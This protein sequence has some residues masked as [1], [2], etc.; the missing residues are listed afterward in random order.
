MLETEPEFDRKLRALYADQDSG[1]AG[2]SRTAYCAVGALAPSG[3]QSP[4]RR[5]GDCHISC[6]DSALRE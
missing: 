1:S 3:A 4:R 6:G 2:K 5:C